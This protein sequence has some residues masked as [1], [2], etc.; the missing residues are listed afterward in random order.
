MSNAIIGSLRVIFG[1]DTAAF[2]KGA[3]EVERRM[4]KTQK[5]LEATADKFTSA[6]AKLSVGLTAPLV[7]FGGMAFK[8]ATDAAELQSAFNQTFGSMAGT[9]NKWAEET[10]NAMGRSTQEMQKAANTFGI[11]FNTAVDPAKAAAMSQTFA[12]LAQDLG[13]FYNTDTETAIEKLRSGLSGESEPLRDFGVFLT[14]ASVKA[15]AMEMGLTGVGNELT[16]QEKILARYQLIM[17]STANAQGDVARTSDGTANQIR[18]AQASFQE[19]QVIIG[20]KLLPVITPLIEKI[21]AAF[22][23]FSKLPEPVQNVS[24]IFAGLAAAFGPILLGI[25]GIVSGFSAMLPVLTALGP[26]LA[27]VSATLLSMLANPIVLGAAAVI[28]GIYLA[29]K[30]WDKIEAIVMRLYNAVKTWIVDKLG[31]V[32]KTVTDKIDTVKRA[33]FNLYDAVVGHSYVPDMVDGIAAQMQRLDNVMVAPVQK[34]TSA[35]KE[36]FKQLE[37]D[38]QGIM[39]NLFRDAREVADFRN[40]LGALDKGIAAG[41]AGGYSKEQLQA[42]R[43]RLIGGASSDVLSNVP[44]PIA[45]QLSRFGQIPL[46]STE[47]IQD[48]LAKMTEAA[49]DNA[50]G[51]GAANVRIVDSF[52]DMADKTLSALQQV[53]SAVKGGGFLDILSAV[54]GFGLQLGSVGAFGKKIQ[55]NINSVPGRAIGGN[56]SAG[57]SYIVGERGPELFTPA[58]SGAIMA[59]KNLSA[60][61]NS[62]QVQVIPS[63]YF[64]V[65]VNGHIQRAAPTIA[66]LGAA[67]ASSRASRTNTRR[68]G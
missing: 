34:A 43:A 31:A 54:V 66:G 12:T 4:A 45:D 1:A 25:G 19:L 62:A 42:G 18:K 50:Q 52:K 7:A 10:G 48:A 24:L 46:G 63:P 36:A 8:A 33:F 28:G 11:F 16:E 17:E 55:T 5:G 60:N 56:V 29:W 26:V 61:N 32:W 53:A 9:M 64:D 22:E 6:G 41:G 37:T 44:L 35:A 30:N 23:W 15:K 57:R 67:E 39:G 58:S 47:G 2:E 21:G 20:T 49:N 65:V 51:I 14:E 59:N 68:I 40:Q 3:T 38:I 13:S 27:T